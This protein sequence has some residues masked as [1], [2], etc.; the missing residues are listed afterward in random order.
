MVENT[1]LGRVV[2]WTPDP[3]F[4][5]GVGLALQGL[6]FLGWRQAVK[7]RVMVIGVRPDE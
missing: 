4:L 5:L 7:L 6:S 1:G 2:D 3:G